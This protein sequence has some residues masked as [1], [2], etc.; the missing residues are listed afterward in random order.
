M[1]LSKDY[2]FYNND[3]I[4]V[5]YLMKK[6][7]LIRR[8]LGEGVP[9][10]IFFD[11]MK[12]FNDIEQKIKHKTSHNKRTASFY[13]PERIVAKIVNELELKKKN[14]EL[15]ILEPASGIGTFVKKISEK[16]YDKKIHFNLNDIDIDAINISKKSF[17]TLKNPNH[18]YSFHNKDFLKKD[19]FINEY[20]LIIGNPPFGIKFEYSDNSVKEIYEAFLDKTMKISKNISLIIPKTILDSP[21]KKEI[22][23][24][25]KNFGVNKIIDLDSSAFKDVRIEVINIILEK[26]SKIVNVMCGNNVVNKELDYI[27]NN[28]LP[29]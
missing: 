15:N 4:S 16:F 12:K 17:K 19:N 14:K 8:V 20:D 18:K 29:A 3:N 5:E 9:A 21:S 24:K 25:I 22:R 6:D 27:A 28:Q 7:S 2:V 13:T 10:N 26:N 23:K 1:N 11:I